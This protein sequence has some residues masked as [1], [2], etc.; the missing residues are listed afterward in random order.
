MV[1]CRWFV[2]TQL[3]QSHKCLEIRLKPISNHWYFFENLLA[4]S[5]GKQNFLPD[6]D[7][8]TKTILIPCSE[9]NILL[10]GPLFNP[11]LCDS[12]NWS[13]DFE[14]TLNTILSSTV[15][16]LNV[17][18]LFQNVVYTTTKNEWARQSNHAQGYEGKWLFL[19]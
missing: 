1:R 9:S 10:A 4:F 3:A 5:L 19:N 8:T 2:Y 12:N 7:R 6:P 16:T 17:V 15:Y 11:N 14:I 13:Y 18:Q